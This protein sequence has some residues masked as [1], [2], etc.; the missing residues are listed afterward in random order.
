[1][2]DNQAGAQRAASSSTNAS[3]S[4]AA[5]RVRSLT[6]GVAF[7][8]TCLSLV[9][10]TTTWWIHDSV[11]DTDHFV[12]ITAPLA[13]DPAVQE[14]LVTVTTT[15]LNEA[16]NLGP[17]GSY[18]VTGISREVYASDAFASIWERA[19]GAV[20]GRIVAVLRGDAPIV[21]TDNGQIVLNAFPLYNAVAARVNGL[22]I[23]IAGRTIQ[24]PALT[25]PEDAD[26]SRAELSA[27]LGRQ[28]SPTFGTI[29]IADATKLE[30]AQG[31]LRL[32]DALVIVLFVVTTLLGVL[33]LVLARRRITMV[34]LLGLGVLVSLLAARLIVNAAADNLSTAISTGGPGAIIGGQIV[35]DLASSYRQFAR[36]V[37]LLGLVAAVAA[38][39]AVWLIERRAGATTTSFVDGWFLALA[40]LVV[41]LVA[42]LLLGLTAATLV[43]VAI[44]WV[45]WLVAVLRSRRPATPEVPKFTPPPP[46]TRA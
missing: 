38:T 24:V 13:E 10:A 7:F 46:A 18:V 26:A 11:L 23:D 25:N 4:K 22:N 36:G 29:P 31:Y 33:T 12:A 32:F 37:L 14:Q 44:A 42:L 2:T 15:Q 1:M 45:I 43:V 27:A 17:I 21:Q 9:L 8:L 20:H 41:A 30:T 39:A 28:L 35:L 40:G 5:S 6:V 19:M 16:L 3:Q 34:A